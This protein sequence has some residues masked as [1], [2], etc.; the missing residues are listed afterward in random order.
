MSEREHFGRPG[1]PE[2]SCGGGRGVRFG[3]QRVDVAGLGRAV[4]N[5]DPSVRSYLPVE[6]LLDE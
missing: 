3:R 2:R 6:E 1:E 5:E 4:G